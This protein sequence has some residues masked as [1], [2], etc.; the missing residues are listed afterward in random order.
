MWNGRSDSIA[1]L[2]QQLIEHSNEIT[3]SIREFESQEQQ[4]ELGIGLN[5]GSHEDEPVPK[6]K[7]GIVMASLQTSFESLLH[8]QAS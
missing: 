7:N 4:E 1:L 5:G 2:E 6:M 8:S 3:R